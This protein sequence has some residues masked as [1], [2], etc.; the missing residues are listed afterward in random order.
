[1]IV[2][3]IARSRFQLHVELRCD[4]KQRAI[5]I[6]EENIDYLYNHVPR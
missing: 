4:G 6:T 2:E 3:H 1:V 5:N